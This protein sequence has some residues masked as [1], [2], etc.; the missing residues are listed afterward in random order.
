MRMSVTFRAVPFSHPM[1]EKSAVADRNRC[2][3]SGAMQSLNLKLV[4]SGRKDRLWLRKRYC[5]RAGLSLDRHP[6]RR[7]FGYVGYYVVIPASLPA[8]R[9]LRAARAF[10]ARGKLLKLGHVARVLCAHAGKPVGPWPQTVRSDLRQSA[11]RH[12]V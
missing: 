12:A 11:Q 6:R 3:Y 9:A 7:G 8:D 5:L 10:K 1:T 4:L 2:G